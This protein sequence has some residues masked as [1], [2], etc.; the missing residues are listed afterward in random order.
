EFVVDLADQGGDPH[1]A[2]NEINKTLDRRA[3]LYTT[4]REGFNG[5]PKFERAIAANNNTHR[6]F[7]VKGT[8]LRDP[9][10]EKGELVGKLSPPLE[11]YTLRRAPA[12]TASH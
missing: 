1:K 5:T 7:Q 6:I 9:T 3:R 12:S 11:M 8:G 4:R 2:V 10:T